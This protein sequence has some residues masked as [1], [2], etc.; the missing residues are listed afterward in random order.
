MEILELAKELGKMIKEDDR[1]KKVDETKKIYAKDSALQQ[2]VFEYNVQRSVLE[3][4]CEKETPDE[5]FLTS[6][7]KR[8]KELYDTITTNPNYL[9]YEEAEN[10]LRMLIQLSTTKFSANLHAPEA[11]PP[12]LAADTIITTTSTEHNRFTKGGI[13]PCR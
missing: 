7:N 5:E 12:A 6:V 10:A 2:A 11:A 9:A 13:S 3:Q 1:A 8:I 4:E